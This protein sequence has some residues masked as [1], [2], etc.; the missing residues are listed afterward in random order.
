[1]SGRREGSCSESSR[2]P[3]S[4]VDVGEEPVD[5]SLV[6]GGEGERLP[7][8]GGGEYSV[9]VGA[10]GQAIDLG[11][12]WL[13][14]S[15]LRHVAREEQAALFLVDTENRSDHPWPTGLL[16]CLQRSRGSGA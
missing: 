1:M 5:S 12:H 10:V 11:F 2:P 4:G 15:A 16:L 7:S 14:A 8:A 3:S 6:L 13:D 9:C